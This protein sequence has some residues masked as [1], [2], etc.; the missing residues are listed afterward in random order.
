MKVFDLRV[1]G[2]F[3]E[4]CMRPIFELAQEQTDK[5]EHQFFVAGCYVRMMVLATAEIAYDAS[6]EEKEKALELFIKGLQIKNYV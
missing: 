3:V 2:P 5:P 1:S 6:E 4:K